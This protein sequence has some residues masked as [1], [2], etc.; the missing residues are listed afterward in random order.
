MTTA[1]RLL[2]ESI[3]R[4]R[5]LHRRVEDAY[6][7]YCNEDGLVWPCPTYRALEPTQEGPAGEGQRGLRDRL[8]D[9]L[10]EIKPRFVISSDGIKVVVEDTI[11]ALLPVIEQYIEREVT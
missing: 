10:I 2:A 6:T 8:I 9:A 7:G 3:A 1:I 4:V 5:E 11:D